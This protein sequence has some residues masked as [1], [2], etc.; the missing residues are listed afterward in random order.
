[1]FQVLHKIQRCHGFELGVN[2]KIS[3]A[4][5]NTYSKSDLINNYGLQYGSQA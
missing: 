1:M 3:H 5:E 4:K 2:K